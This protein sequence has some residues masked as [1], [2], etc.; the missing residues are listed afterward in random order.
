M[1]SRDSK[2]R[3]T[4]RTTRK[5]DYKGRFMQYYSYYINLI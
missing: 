5:K 4:K 1:K 3:F 2:G